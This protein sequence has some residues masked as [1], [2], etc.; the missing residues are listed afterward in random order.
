M[1]YELLK[2]LKNLTLGTVVFHSLPEFGITI[3]YFV[4][5]FS[6]CDTKSKVI[7][8]YLCYWK[9]IVWKEK[10]GLVK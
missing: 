10:W 7:R 9:G 1:W 4:V 6:L 5:L 3:Q 8:F 2:I